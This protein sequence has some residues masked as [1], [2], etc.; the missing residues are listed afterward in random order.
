M[1]RPSPNIFKTQHPG[2]NPFPPYRKRCMEGGADFFF[3]KST[4]AEKIVEVLKKLIKDKQ[5]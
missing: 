5:N 4:E 1:C 3:D 2:E